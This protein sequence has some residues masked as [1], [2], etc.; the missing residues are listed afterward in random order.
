MRIVIS[1]LTAS[2]LYTA[3]P[4]SAAEGELA[5]KVTSAQ[6]TTA[7]LELQS[8]KKPAVGDRVEIY[9]M[10]PGLDEEASVATGVVTQIEGKL[11]NVSISKRTARVRSGQQARIVPNQLVGADGQQQLTDSTEPV[12]KSAGST[13]RA[14]LGAVVRD[15][16]PGIR[17]QLDAEPSDAEPSDAEPSGAEP[18]GGVVVLAPKPWSPAEKC[19]LCPGDQILRIGGQPVENA[20]WLDGWVA[21]RSVGEELALDLVRDGE[22]TTLTV[23][24]E[25][26]PENEQSVA[27]L[28]RAAESGSAWGQYELARTLLQDG[29]AKEPAGGVGLVPSC[30]RAR[31]RPRALDARQVVP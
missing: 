11:V 23:T 3:I 14:W 25:P 21:G 7:Q 4:T 9:V 8:E 28:R 5:A 13:A 6:G 15:V 18:S 17:Q 2:M 1:L 26:A 20:K 12:S 31:L 24:L 27:Y 16:P 10:I 22:P 19:G 29:K 30:R